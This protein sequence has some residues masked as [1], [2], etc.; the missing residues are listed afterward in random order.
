M[1]CCSSIRVYAVG[2]SSRLIELTIGETN[3]TFLLI[4][5][6]FTLGFII[7]DDN[8]PDGHA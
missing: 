4:I 3:M 6:M 5:V 1:C 7:L 8:M 2:Y